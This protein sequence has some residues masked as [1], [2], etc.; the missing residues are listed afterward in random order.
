LKK[1]CTIEVLNLE[2]NF[3]DSACLQD[4]AN[5][6]GANPN[7]SLQELRVSHQQG[8]GKSYGR[9][10]ELSFGETMQKNTT[11][12]KLGLYCDD[13]H[14]RDVIDR[15]VLR[16]IDRSRRNRKVRSNSEDESEL[17]MEDKT[18][19]SFTLQRPPR[20]SVQELLG[21][22]DSI[23]IAFKDF[24][25]KNKKVPTSTQMQAAAKAVGSPMKF[26]EVKPTLNKC[27]TLLLNAAIRTSIS[28]LDIY[29]SEIKGT[30]LRWEAGKTG[31]TMLELLDETQTK[32]FKCVSTK[33][34]AVAVSEMWAEWLQGIYQGSALDEE[35][36][37]INDDK[38]V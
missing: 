24:L 29:G 17:T 21:D 9:P 31:N 2:S 30:L 5:G 37:D 28:V 12:T 8:M 15:A 7:T 34:P 32:K 10:V 23:V 38:S 20:V 6:I 3:I 18:L 35:D 27:Q 33:D 16:N 25:V 19:N 4:V 11:I 14:W 13:A 1:N 26:S 36:D 22:G